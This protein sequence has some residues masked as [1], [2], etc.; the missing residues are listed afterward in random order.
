MFLV[1]GFG[2]YVLGFLGFLG[3]GP[4]GLGFEIRWAWVWASVGIELEAEV[5]IEAG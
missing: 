2:F 4:F 5:W 3:F 1:L